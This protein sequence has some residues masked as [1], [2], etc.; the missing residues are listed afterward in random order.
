MEACTIGYIPTIENPDHHP[1]VLLL[2]Q[3]INILID[4]ASALY[5]LH[6]EC[7]QPLVHCDL[8]P[9]NVLLDG[10][11]VAHLSDFGLARLLSTIQVIP[12]ERSSTIGIT[13]GYVPP[14]YGMG[15]DV[16]IQGDMYSFGILI[17]EFF[18][19]N[20]L[21][22]VSPTIV[23]TIQSEQMAS[24]SDLQEIM[25]RIHPN[26]E[27]CICCLF[28]IE[29]SCSMELPHERMSAADVIKELISIKKLFHSG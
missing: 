14:E 17:L 20:L 23:P 10:D 5:Y 16:S 28:R 1:R 27:K 29:L 8:K 13:I 7:G 6:H 25:V 15:C 21:Q 11:M 19:N 2:H 24:S 22:V 12:N 26:M 4:V 9:S 18:P 3:V